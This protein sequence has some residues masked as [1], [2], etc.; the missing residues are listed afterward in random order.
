[1]EKAGQIQQLKLALGEAEDIKMH[2]Q[3][4]QAANSSLAD[5]VS[6]LT[7]RIEILS[8]RRPIVWPKSQISIVK[9]NTGDQG[10]AGRHA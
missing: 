1:M 2:A 10:K 5:Q 6:D 9:T 8:E 7:S 4:L 3:S